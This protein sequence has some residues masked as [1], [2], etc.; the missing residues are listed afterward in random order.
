MDHLGMVGLSA[1]RALASGVSGPLSMRSGVVVGLA[2]GR[3]LEWS[4]PVLG[5]GDGWSCRNTPPMAPVHGWIQ[6]LG[7]NIRA[8]RAEDRANGG[9][10][11]GWH[12]GRMVVFWIVLI[13]G[14][15]RVLWSWGGMGMKP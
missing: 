4:P 5:V 13:A 9:W 3:R 15:H 1:L 12:G 10:G 2:A 11:L 6:V 14:H 8:D 7:A